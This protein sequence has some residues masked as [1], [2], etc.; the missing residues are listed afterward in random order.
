MELRSE[1]WKLWNLASRST[2]RMEVF[3]PSFISG[4]MPT[5][6]RPT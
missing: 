2:A 3:K 1:S 5:G 4:F 6:T